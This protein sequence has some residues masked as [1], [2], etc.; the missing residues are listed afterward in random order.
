[1]PPLRLTASTFRADALSGMTTCAVR[2]SRL[3]ARASAEPWLPEE[4]VATAPLIPAS[5]RWTTALLAPRNLNAPVRCRCS[6]LHSS[7]QPNSALRPSLARTGVRFTR[8]RMRRCASQTA[9]MSGRS[10]DSGLK[11]AGSVGCGSWKMRSQQL[12][13]IIQA[14][15]TPGLLLSWQIR[16]HCK[17]GFVA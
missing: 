8:L 17:E 2:W 7:S 14:L 16:S 15:R 9:L 1:M 3:A 10:G 6:H 4:W 13:H 12:G 5:R 11:F